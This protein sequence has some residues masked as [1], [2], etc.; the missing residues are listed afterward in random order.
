MYD[1]GVGA[2]VEV[3]EAGSAIADVI[4]SVADPETGETMYGENTIADVVAPW[5]KDANGA[6]VPTRYE[7]SGSVPTWVVAH[8]RGM[9]V[10]G[11]TVLRRPQ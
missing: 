11:S 1:F 2:T 6:D 9:Y 10:S 5:A 3:Q 4:E 8:S 7:A